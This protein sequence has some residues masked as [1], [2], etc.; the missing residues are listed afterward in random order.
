MPRARLSQTEEFTSTRDQD[1]AK[2]SGDDQ[3]ANFL[4]AEYTLIQGAR[5]SALNLVEGRIKFILTL[6]SA[7]IAVIALLYTRSILMEK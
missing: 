3:S 4:L 7:Q 6:Q 1:D 2:L 5:E